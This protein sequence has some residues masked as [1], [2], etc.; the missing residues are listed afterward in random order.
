LLACQM[1]LIQVGVVVLLPVIFPLLFLGLCWKWMIVKLGILLEEFYA[2]VESN[3]L[4]FIS[5]SHEKPREAV[6]VIYVLSG[7]PTKEKVVKEFRRVYQLRDKKKE[8]CYW[9]LG[10]Y[11][12]KWMGYW[13]W[14]KVANF[15]IEN[16]V[17]KK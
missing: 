17:C 12:V 10:T 9:K 14:K 6:V 13:F 2:P 4:A 5:D 11:P 1:K 7:T 15:R 3:D 8:R 16:Q